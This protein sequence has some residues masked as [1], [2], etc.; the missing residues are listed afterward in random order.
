MNDP[1][2]PTLILFYDQYSF[3]NLRV[4]ENVKS[5]LIDK[6]VFVSLNMNRHP[7]SFDTFKVN[8]LPTVVAFLNGYELWRI[9][10]NFSEESILA[11][12]N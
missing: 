4:F 5:L 7:E 1:A 9:S 10:G 6:A 3:E 2:L 12:F 11:N 8:D